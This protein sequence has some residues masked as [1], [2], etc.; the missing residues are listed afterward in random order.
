MANKKNKKSTTKGAENYGSGKSRLAEERAYLKASKTSDVKA[1]RNLEEIFNDL[2][3]KIPAPINFLS[4]NT[5]QKGVENLSQKA[6]RDILERLPAETQQELFAHEISDMTPDLPYMLSVQ[7]L[8]GMSQLNA[9]IEV[10]RN[11]QVARSYGSAISFDFVETAIARYISQFLCDFRG[12][13]NGMKSVLKH[14]KSYRVVQ[15]VAGQTPSVSLH[16]VHVI[17]Q[18]NYRGSSLCSFFDLFLGNSAYKSK[19]ITFS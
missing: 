3:F 11:E 10:L 15:S 16:R 6:S 9:I 12:K 8:Q 18:D 13:K 7:H 2:R 17:L 19:V 14:V 1:K 4:V 5:R